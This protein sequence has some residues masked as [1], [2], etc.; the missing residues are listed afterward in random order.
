MACNTGLDHF[1][2]RAENLVE[3]FL[4]RV[5]HGKWLAC[6]QHFVTT[7][8]LNRFKVLLI[9]IFLAALFVE[10]SL[11]LTEEIV[12]DYV[13]LLASALTGSFGGASCLDIAADTTLDLLHYHFS[14]SFFTRCNLDS[15]IKLR[16]L[17][18]Y[19]FQTSIMACSNFTLFLD[20]RFG[21]FINWS[22][23]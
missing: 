13:Y 1:L 4:D 3:V 14:L 17:V 22:L 9:I 18:S 12:V 10:V 5:I 6:D 7:L 21:I 20:Y 11:R 8:L 2:C 15:L 23:A 16:L 19:A